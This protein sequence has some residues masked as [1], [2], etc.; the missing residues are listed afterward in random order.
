MGSNLKLALVSRV[1]TKCLLMNLSE[2]WGRGREC[3][4]AHGGWE[5][6]EAAR[7]WYEIRIV[8]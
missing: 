5:T 7:S 8:E 1:E 3:G 4:V 6:P 2:Y